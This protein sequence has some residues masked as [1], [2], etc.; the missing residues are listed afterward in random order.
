MHIPFSQ[1]IIPTLPRANGTLKAMTVCGT[2][3]P[4]EETVADVADATCKRCI[5]KH[6]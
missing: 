1:T 6:R 3:A 2:I 5:R 4:I